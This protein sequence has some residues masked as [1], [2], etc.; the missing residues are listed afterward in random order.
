MI[1]PSE[2]KSAV[3]LLR[4]LYNYVKQ[5]ANHDPKV[6]DTL[7]TIRIKI[8]DAREKELELLEKVRELQESLK[9]KSMPYD[10]DVEAYYE[11]EGDGSRTHYCLRCADADGK[12][13][14]LSENYPRGFICRVCGHQYFSKE[15]AEITR[16][17]NEMKRASRPRK[18][19]SRSSLWD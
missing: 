3:D 13:C 16:N 4:D 11:D 5:T 9:T 2:I 7:E 15:D 8:L 12:K 18:A 17:E 6:I 19:A 10:R 14:K 1:N